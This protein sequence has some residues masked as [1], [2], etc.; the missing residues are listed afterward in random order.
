[1]KEKMSSNN[2]PHYHILL[3]TQYPTLLNHLFHLLIHR[4]NIG[5]ET[6]RGTGP[7]KFA[8]AHIPPR[9]PLLFLLEGPWPDLATSRAHTAGPF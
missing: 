6:N 7:R 2:R 4:S 8:R 1:M 9:L 3:K 5:T